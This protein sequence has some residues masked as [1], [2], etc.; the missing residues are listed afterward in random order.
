MDIHGPGLNTV[1][2]SVA[3]HL[4]SGA[5]GPYGSDAPAVGGLTEGSIQVPFSGSVTAPS[6]ARFCPRRRDMLNRPAIQ[7]RA[8]AFDLSMS[9][10]FGTLHLVVRDWD[11]VIVCSDSRGHSG[12]G[13]IGDDFEKLCKCGQWTA[14][15]ISGNLTIPPDIRVSD[16]VAKLCAQ[17]TL[18]DSPEKLLS[19]IRDNLHRNFLPLL[20]RLNET[21]AP[22]MYCFFS[23]HVIQRTRDGHVTL[24]VLEYPIQMVASGERRV[25]GPEIRPYT[26]KPEPFIFPFGNG[27]CLDLNQVKERLLNR[28]KLAKER[29]PFEV[30][31][32]FATARAANKTCFDQVGG[33]IDV[34]VIDS[35]GFHW[36]RQKPPRPISPS[37]G[38]FG[39]VVAAMN[40]AFSGWYLC[41]A[42]WV[43]A[44]RRR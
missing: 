34:A 44:A 2:V 14:C 35:E 19:A 10:T 24:S 4:S 40:R 13:P 31:A 36:A 20:L 43:R 32:L 42:T 26:L 30:D 12:D 21:G 9:L 33:P 39:R 38:R 28:P 16:L 25:G 17:D 11:R 1:V 3:S 18:Q 15:F 5:V 7:A 22:E 41:L 37:P 27:D 6:P 23:A 8:R 29:L